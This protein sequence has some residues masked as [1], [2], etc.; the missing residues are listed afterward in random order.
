LFPLSEEGAAKVPDYRYAVRGLFSIFVEIE[1]VNVRSCF[2]NGT[3]KNSI[4]N[5][6]ALIGA[7]SRKNAELWLENSSAD[8]TLHLIGALLV[9]LVVVAINAT[10]A[11]YCTAT[12]SEEDPTTTAAPVAVVNNSKAEASTSNNVYILDDVHGWIPARVVTTVGGTCTVS[13]PKYKDEQHIISDG[14]HSAK[15]FDRREIS[16]KEY[17]GNVL[18]LQNVDQDGV[19]MEVQDMVDLPFLHEAAILYNLKARHVQGKPY[20]R[21]GDI[22]IAVN[23]YQVRIYNVLKMSSRVC[24][25]SHSIMHAFLLLFPISTV[26]RRLVCRTNS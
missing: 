18:P 20:T 15:G 17:P 9:L 13:I 24:P 19:L 23:P 12:M 25:Y 22:I 21:T 10:N 3:A 14:G 16:L 5:L 11:S 26:D 1:R 8:V 4:P 6:R 7:V 2:E